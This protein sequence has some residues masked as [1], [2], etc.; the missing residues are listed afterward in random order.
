[1]RRDTYVTDLTARYIPT[2]TSLSVPPSSSRS[3]KTRG[4]GDAPRLAALLLSPVSGAP[5]PEA[6]HVLS[7][8][9]EGTVV[10]ELATVPSEPRLVSHSYVEEGGDAGRTRITAYNPGD[11]EVRVDL[12]LRGFDG[13]LIQA[14]TTAFR[15]AAG[16]STVQFL[17][18]L[19]SFPEQVRGLMT[20]V[21][22][23]PIAVSVHSMRENLRPSSFLD[24]LLVAPFN[25]ADRGVPS[26]P[27]VQSLFLT[28]DTVHRLSLS[29]SGLV[30]LSGSLSFRDESGAPLPVE[31]E[32]GTSTTAGYALPPGG[33]ALFRFRV[34]AAGPSGTGVRTAQVRILPRIG[35]GVRT[36]APRPG[37]GEPAPMVQLVEERTV[38]S[39]AGRPVI[40]P[41]TAPPSRNVSRFLVPVDLALRDSGVVLTNRLGVAVRAGLIL[42]NAAGTTVGSAEVSV[43][44]GGQMAISCRSH[45]P[46]AGA[47]E[48][49]LAGSV[50]GPPGA[51][52]DAVGFLRR[53]N[54]R[55]E[56]ILAGFP[57]LD[58]AGGWSEGVTVFPLALDGDSWR[59]EWSFWNATP[60]ELVTGLV[61][62]GDGRPTYF[63]FE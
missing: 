40:L 53:I 27:A 9:V 11:K 23:G 51:T 28:V 47:L 5:A 36:L 4:Q 10:T 35:Q 21:S 44:A 6:L 17:S 54:E 45:F 18:D 58:G 13:T 29:N 63:P 8:T 26:S 57:V 52:V 19:L 38:G 3:V 32:T 55:G 49:T 41:R 37:I 25:D 59:S 22:N 48:G 31:L 7:G 12:V 2:I 34:P 14:T 30:S 42:R 46:E 43:P 1:M 33:T 15:I 20:L 62:H 60:T 61:F 16:S 56:E 50:V 39:T 24:P